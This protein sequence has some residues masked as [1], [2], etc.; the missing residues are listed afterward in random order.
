MRTEL[1]QSDIQAIAEKVVE[2]LLPKLQQEDDE[3]LN[4]EQASVL[5]GTSRD[6][7]YQWV[8]MTKHG[9]RDFPFQKQGRSLRFWRSELKKWMRPR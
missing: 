5:L 1:E 8:F 4:I 3:L 6:Q 7:I 9:V 2:I